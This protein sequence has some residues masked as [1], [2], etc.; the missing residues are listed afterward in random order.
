MTLCL[1]TNLEPI[2]NELDDVIRLFYGDVS[3]VAEGGDITLVHT[4]FENGGQ[5]TETLS[6]GEVSRVKTS[7]VPSGELERKRVI[8]RAAK[9]ALFL[10]LKQLTSTVPPWG[11]LTGI[12]PTRLM[13]EAMDE[14]LS[15]GE[16]E[17]RLMEEFFV[18]PEK[19]A[20]L[21]SIVNAQKGLIFP[22]ADSFDLYIHIPFCATRCAYCSF[23]TGEVGDGKLVGPYVYALLNELRDGA[24][25]MRQLG[26]KMRAGYVGGGTPTAIPAPQLERILAAARELFGQGEEFTVEAGRP[27]TITPEQ[28]ETLRRQRVTRISVNPQTFSDETLQRIGRA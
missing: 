27:D 25:L 3:F 28:L 13:Y 1:K 8:K 14:G 5:Y 6:C 23:A 21:K 15:V 4:H 19:A 7:G 16:A 18:S 22:P 9:T 17:A 10:L 2:R 20:L 12:R 24:A 11:S 26:L